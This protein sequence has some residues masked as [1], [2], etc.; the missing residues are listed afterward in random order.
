LSGT[1][2]HDGVTFAEMLVEMVE[3]R[4]V[5]GARLP[6]AAAALIAVLVAVSRSRR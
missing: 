5:G 2:H 6:A 3:G 1:R 4:R